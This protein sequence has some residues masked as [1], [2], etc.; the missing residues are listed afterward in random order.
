MSADLTDVNVQSEEIDMVFG[1]LP[2]IDINT[3]PE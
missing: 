2:G 1:A 3:V